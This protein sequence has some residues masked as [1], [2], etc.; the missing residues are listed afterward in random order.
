[1]ALGVNVV[2]ADFAHT[3]PYGAIAVKKIDR[4]TAKFVENKRFLCGKTT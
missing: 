1:M 3:T 2:C 4:K